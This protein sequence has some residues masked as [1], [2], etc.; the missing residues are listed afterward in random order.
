M[1]SA[2]LGDLSPDMAAVR[3]LF[4]RYVEAN[5]HSYH[6]A[7]MIIQAVDDAPSWLDW[8]ADPADRTDATMDSLT[9]EIM[10]RIRADYDL[11]RL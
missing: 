10:S 1:P 4:A 5:Q 8:L 9:S 6:T 11:G 7:Q 2:H 3:D